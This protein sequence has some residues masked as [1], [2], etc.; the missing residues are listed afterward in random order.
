[1][2]VSS[3]CSFYSV[4]FIFLFCFKHNKPLL[5]SAGKCIDTSSSYLYK[6]QADSTSDW[7]TCMSQHY[8][9]TEKGKKRK[10]KT[11]EIEATAWRKMSIKHRFSSFEGHKVI[12]NV[13]I[14]FWMFSVVCVWER[15][16]IGEQ[17]G[18][19]LCESNKEG[20]I[21]TKTSVDYWKWTR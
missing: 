21:Q 8:I 16:E 15:G 20:K 5:S 13:S 14:W 2:L 17:G 10:V 18:R 4:I 3:T 6:Y 19:R 1:M 12:T 9:L 7:F 11:I